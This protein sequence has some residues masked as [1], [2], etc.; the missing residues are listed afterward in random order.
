MRAGLS[1]LGPSRAAFVTDRRSAR[2]ASLRRTVGIV[3]R[4]AQADAERPGF[5]PLVPVMVTLT[6]RTADDHKPDNITR[7][8]HTVRKWYGRKKW[9]FRYVWVA[10]LQKRGVLHYH[11]CVWV[12]AGERLPYFDAAGWWPHGDSNLKRAR[13]AVRY[14]LKYL[15][16]GLDTGAFPPGARIH[17]HGGTDHG[18]RRALRWY[19]RPAFVRARGGIDADWRR[20]RGGGWSDPDGLV[21][22]SEFVRTWLGDQWGLLRVADYGRPFPADGPYSSWTPAWP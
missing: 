4:A 17:G 19:R 12:P 13:C 15:S 20:V 14:L 21:I 1:D 9:P 3:G 22:P 7:C 10:E 11:V 6:Y 2:V 8:L 18:V 5:R 16:K